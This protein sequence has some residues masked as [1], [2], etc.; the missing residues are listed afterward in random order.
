MMVTASWRPYTQC[1]FLT[2]RSFNQC[3]TCSYDA[4]K[5]RASHDLTWPGLSR[6]GVSQGLV[7]F[8]TGCM[9]CWRTLVLATVDALLLA[10]DEALMTVMPSMA[11]RNICC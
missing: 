4:Q 9:F 5:A 10:N 7:L 1:V 11:C 2:Y 6:I 8:D 3:H